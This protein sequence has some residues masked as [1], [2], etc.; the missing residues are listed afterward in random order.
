MKYAP[1]LLL[2]ILTISGLHCVPTNDTRYSFQCLNLSGK[3]FRVLVVFVL[4]LYCY[5]SIDTIFKPEPLHQEHNRSIFIEVEEH[6]ALQQTVSR[7]YAIVLRQVFKLTDITLMQ[8]INGFNPT[9]TEENRIDKQL[10]AMS[11]K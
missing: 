8:T 2:I 11:D 7:I 3:L 5:F 9:M 4:L 10:Q 1:K 6:D